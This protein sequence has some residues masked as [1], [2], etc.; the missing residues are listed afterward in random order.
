LTSAINNE[1]EAYQCARAFQTPF[2]NWSLDFSDSQTN[3]LKSN[4]FISKSFIQI[5]TPELILLN[6]TNFDAVNLIQ[7]DSTIFL[8]IVNYSSKAV[9]DLIRLSLIQIDQ[10]QKVDLQN[11]VME[12]ISI[13]EDGQSFQ[14]AFHSFEVSTYQIRLRKNLN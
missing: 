3:T 14:V 4:D 5:N 9:T 8:R 10:I 7:T 12:E 11:N 13:Q 6:Y 2:E 1:W